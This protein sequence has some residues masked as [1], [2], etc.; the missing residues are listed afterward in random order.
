MY[1]LLTVCTRVLVILTLLASFTIGE[2]TVQGHTPAAKPAAAA[3][4]RDRRNDT[5]Y[6]TRTGKKYHR[7]D[8]RYLSQ[9]KIPIKRWKAEQEGYEPCK[10]CRP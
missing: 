10:V 4:D 6:I 9:S 5:V 1:K 3:R 7:G 2:S 8:C